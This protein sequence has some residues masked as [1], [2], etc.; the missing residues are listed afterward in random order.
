V[1]SGIATRPPNN[2]F[3]WPVRSVALGRNGLAVACLA[4][5]GS[6]DSLRR[7]PGDGSQAR[8][9]PNRGGVPCGLSTYGATAL[10]CVHVAILLHLSL[11]TGHR[12][13]GQKTGGHSIIRALSPA[14][15]QLYLQQRQR[16]G[17]NL[18][19]LLAADSAEVRRST[20]GVRAYARCRGLAAEDVSDCG[21]GPT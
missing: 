2:A 21:C 6:R 11:E 10:S 20:E 18:A 16:L 17:A 4:G 14:Y 7:Y 3:A 5:G 12:T 19:C 15:S 9:T 8:P 1:C 13:I